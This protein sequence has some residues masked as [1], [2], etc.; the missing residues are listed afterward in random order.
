MGRTCNGPGCCSLTGSRLVMS[1]RPSAPF[2]SAVDLPAPIHLVR[3]TI[4]DEM[5]ERGMDDW[6]D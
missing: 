2:T 1:S 5:T 4:L 6:S 3:V